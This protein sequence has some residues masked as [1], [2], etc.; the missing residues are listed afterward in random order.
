MDFL[1]ST[2]SVLDLNPAHQERL[3]L[4]REP[5]SFDGDTKRIFV[6]LEING[7]TARA[8]LDTGATLL[9][10][11]SRKNAMKLQL[12]EEK[13]SEPIVAVTYK[14]LVERNLV[15]RDVSVKGL[16]KEI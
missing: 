6:D 9:A 13:L 16:G 12:K 5:K 1:T 4:Y 11:C 15:A 2:C 3:W 8:F 10:D 14:G 7:R